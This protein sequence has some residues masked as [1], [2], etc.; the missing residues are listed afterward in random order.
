MTREEA[1]RELQE[2]LG[3]INEH[4]V[5]MTKLRDSLQLAA[6]GDVSVSCLDD[7]RAC[8]N[9]MT[10]ARTNVEKAKKVVKARITARLKD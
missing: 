7:I 1:I 6:K 3:T 4:Q 5:N 8:L 10:E 9:G 2:V